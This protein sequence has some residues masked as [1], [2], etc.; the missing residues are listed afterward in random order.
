LE[1]WIPQGQFLEGLGG[2]SEEEVV[3]NLF[4]LEDEGIQVVG[5]GDDHMKVMSG[6]E[7]IFASFEPFC[8]VQ[9]LAFGAVAVAAGV[10]GDTGESAILVTDI[11]VSP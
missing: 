2:G 10:V 3:E 9:I 11:D 6:E 4:V 5:E 1:P 7:S 8:L